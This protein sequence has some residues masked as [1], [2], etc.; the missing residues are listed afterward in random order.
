MIAASETME[1]M[2]GCDFASSEARI[3]LIGS[4]SVL[5]MA[6][7]SLENLE[8]GLMMPALFAALSCHLIWQAYR[9]WKKPYIRLQ[10]NHL[11]VFE[12][13]KPKHY[14]DLT[15]VQSWK[16]GLNRTILQM[17]DGLSVSISHLNFI[18]REDAIAFR[19]ALAARIA[20]VAA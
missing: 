3:S 10:A 11:I 12:Y 17:N 9:S 1:P 6:A 18:K 16:K 8:D 4:L 7:N 15:Q 13:G 2:S 19:A 5:W 20:S 14:I